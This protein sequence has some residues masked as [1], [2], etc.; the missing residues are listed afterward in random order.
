M[1]NG[2]KCTF[3]V[4]SYAVDTE[5]C[6]VGQS[7]KIGH[8]G[9]LRVVLHNRGQISRVEA[10]A[11]LDLCAIDLPQILYRSGQMVP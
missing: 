11:F 5:A 10:A 7:A 6:D 3:C 4:S 9:S 2:L 1:I 8:G